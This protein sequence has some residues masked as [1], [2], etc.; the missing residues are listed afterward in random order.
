[1]FTQAGITTNAYVMDNGISSEFI[2]ALT[3]NN[4]SYQL[5]PPR[6]YRLNLA[7]KGIQTWKGHFK[8]D[9]VSVDPNFSL[10]KWD[11]LIEQVNITLNLLRTSRSNPKLSAHT[12]MFG[13]FNFTVTPLAPPGTKII[14]HIKSSQR[15]S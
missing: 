11:R 12:Y 2:T 15:R 10:T 3:K 8:A 7:Q 13:E 1:M 4:T 9:L 14:T 6:I 5:V